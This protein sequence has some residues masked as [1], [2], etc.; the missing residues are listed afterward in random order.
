M[1]QASPQ[2]EILLGDETIMGTS[3]HAT[4]EYKGVEFESASAPENRLRL[5]I[6]PIP[7]EYRADTLIKTR[8]RIIS[9]SSGC[10]TSAT[11]YQSVLMMNPAE[12]KNW[13]GSEFCFCYG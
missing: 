11:D 7:D 6:G 3:L 1:E 2:T 4:H 13:E 5:E 9:P 12:A 8:I 10:K